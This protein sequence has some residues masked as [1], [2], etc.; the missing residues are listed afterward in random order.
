MRADGGHLH[1]VAAPGGRAAFTPD[2]H[3][4]VYECGSCRAGD[5][6]FI[7]R[8]DGSD[9]PGRRLTKN[10]FPHE[11]DEGAQVSPNGGTVAFVRHKVDEKLQASFAVNI[12]GKHTR[13][14]LPYTLEISPKLDWAPDGSHILITEYAD[15]PHGH[16]P[17][18]AIVRPDGSSG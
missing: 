4:L 2:G 14:L 7:M 10:P 8:A 12:N 17:N 3:H 18:V 6:I 1:Q 5:G 9:A 15:H 16:T 13:K 11:G